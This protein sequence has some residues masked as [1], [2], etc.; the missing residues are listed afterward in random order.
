MALELGLASSTAVQGNISCFRFARDPS[1][2]PFDTDVCHVHNSDHAYDQC[3]ENH[4][5][6]MY[7]TL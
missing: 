6:H 5:G 2:G 7:R 1:V 4:Q 3:G